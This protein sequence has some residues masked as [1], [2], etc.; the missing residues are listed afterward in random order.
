MD[1]IS[2]LL[3][4]PLEILKLT[5]TLLVFFVIAAIVY[6]LFVLYRKETEHQF[7]HS[8]N[9]VY[10]NIKVPKENLVSSLAVESIFSQMHALHSALTFANIYVEGKIQQWYSLELISM[11]GKISFIIRVPKTA[12]NLVESSFYA[13]YPDAEITEIDDYMENFDFDPENPKD[14]DI[15]GTE[16][17]LVEDFVFPIKTYKDFEHPS[18]EEKI[19]DPLANL[20]E[21]FNNMQPYEFYGIQIIIQ[22]LGDDEWKPMGERKVKELIGE[23]APHDAKL[24]DLVLAPVNKFATFSYKDFILGGGHAHAHG[25]EDAKAPKNNWMSLTETQ[26]ER[27]GLVEKKMGKP[28]YRTKIRHMYVAPKDRFDPTKKGLVIGSYRPFGSSNSNKFKPE[29]KNTWTGVDYV[30]SPELEKPYLDWK[31]KKRKRHFFKGYKNRDIH[32]GNPMFVLN[33]EEIA[34]IYHFPITTKAVATSIEKTASKRAQP[35]ANL[36]IIE[37]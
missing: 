33:V 17:K 1:I 21:A 20:F 24:S 25:E 11:G 30:F 15:W 36:P 34:T 13:H 18:A 29:T 37:E 16:F 22:P 8:I 28:G 14:I 10:L 27:V 4:N 31:L 23:E 5:G 2:G 9:W 35:P 3:P 6:I 19:I 7:V 26:K 32:I 12:R